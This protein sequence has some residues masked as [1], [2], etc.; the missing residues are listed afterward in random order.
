MILM[1]GIETP[2]RVLGLLRAKCLGIERPS[3]CMIRC[4]SNSF[5]AAIVS[6]LFLFCGSLALRADVPQSKFELFYQRL[7]SDCGNSFFTINEDFN[8]EFPKDNQAD[9]LAEVIERSA[10]EAKDTLILAQAIYFLETF[11]HSDGSRPWNQRL[12]DVLLAQAHHADP[13]V[14]IALASF[15]I[16]RHDPQQR[17]LILSFL[18]DENDDVRNRVLDEINRNKWS[19]ALSIDSE[20]IARTKPEGTHHKSVVS[21]RQYTNPE[22]NERAGEICS[23]SQQPDVQAYYLAYIA[24]HRDDPDYEVSVDTAERF[25]K[26]NQENIDYRKAVADEKKRAGFLHANVDFLNPTVTSKPSATQFEQR[27]FPEQVKFVYWLFDTK[28]STTSQ[29]ACRYC[30]LVVS[31]EI[32]A[33]LVTEIAERATH[34]PV[35]NEVILNVLI[36]SEHQD[37][38]SLQIGVWSEKLESLVWQQKD[39]PDRRIRNYVIRY[40]NGWKTADYRGRVLSFLN[41]KDP[42]VLQMA[43]DAIATWPDRMEI[44]E[45]YLTEHKADS[46]YGDGVHFIHD[47][48]SGW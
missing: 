29:Y 20:Y 4:A 1:I 24:K 36:F 27:S 5:L 35:N 25:Y 41:D 9:V 21:A 43:I 31:P 48:T 39:N 8:R 32:K 46:T 42:D 40:I 33:Q 28:D 15:L 22:D 11:V 13:S 47:L 6:G 23:M 45:K 38:P 14:R 17:G 10:K 18:D 19:D 3:L 16:R 37:D 12:E 2:P 34:S 44:Y 30:H 26:S 7:N